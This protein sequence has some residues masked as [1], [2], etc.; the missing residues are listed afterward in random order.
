MPRG[1][2]LDQC[3]ITRCGGKQYSK[4]LCRQCY[5]AAQ[6]LVGRN[7]T[8][9]DELAKLELTN[10]STGAKFLCAFDKATQGRLS[11]KGKWRNK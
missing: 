9:W 4:G 10:E 5:K 1:K 11:T 8:T 3:I 6:S 7:L 2:P